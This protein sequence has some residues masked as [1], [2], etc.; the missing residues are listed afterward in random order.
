MTNKNVNPYR[1]TLNGFVKVYQLDKLSI[2]PIK[3]KENKT[4]MF[5]LEGI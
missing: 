5:L 1:K 2:E 3:D 4:E